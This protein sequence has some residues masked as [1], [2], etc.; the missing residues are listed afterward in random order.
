MC[1]IGSNFV[2]VTSLSPGIV[3]GLPSGAKASLSEQPFFRA[4]FEQFSP[5]GP[6]RREV[7]SEPSEKLHR[8]SYAA[9]RPHWAARSVIRLCLG[10][11]SSSASLLGTW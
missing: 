3:E 6:A 11:L 10:P 4:V 2:C 8:E 7:I 9:G 5:S 1:R